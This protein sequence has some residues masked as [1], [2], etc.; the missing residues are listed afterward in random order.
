MFLLTTIIPLFTTFLQVST[1][2]AVVKGIDVTQI[3]RVF[4]QSATLSADA[5][6]QFFEA[7]RTVAETELYSGGTPRVFAVQKM[8]EVV[9]YNITRPIPVWQRLW[10]VIADFFSR[11]G[12]HPHQQV[13]MYAIDALRQLVHKFLERP[14]LVAARCQ[15][16]T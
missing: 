5:V 13:A 3:E 8:L 14:E 1:S 10:V 9:Y 4:T 16:R 2:Q 6:E 7:L 12:C 11:A 15:V